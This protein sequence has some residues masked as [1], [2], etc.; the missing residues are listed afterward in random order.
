VQSRS[1]IRLDV[2]ARACAAPSHQFSSIPGF[3]GKRTRSPCSQRLREK[4]CTNS[5]APSWAPCDGL[6]DSG[7]GPGGHG[8]P[9]VGL[10]RARSAGGEALADPR[11]G[12]H[13]TCSLSL[14]RVDVAPG[15]HSHSLSLSHCLGLAHTRNVCPSLCVCVRERERERERERKKERT[16]ERER[17]RKRERERVST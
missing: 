14:R 12:R 4:T 8:E 3:L 17:E 6:A 2:C 13:K 5:V 9:G 1:G 16:R 7:A 10:H 15:R 11:K